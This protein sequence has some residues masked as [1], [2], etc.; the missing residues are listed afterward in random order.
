[1]SLGFCFETMKNFLGLNWQ[2]DFYLHKIT[3]P[4]KVADFKIILYIVILIYFGLSEFKKNASWYRYLT[5]QLHSCQHGQMLLL[6][7]LFTVHNTLNKRWSWL[8]TIIESMAKD[9]WKL[10]FRKEVSCCVYV[11]RMFCALWDEIKLRS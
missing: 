6:F 8:E 4:R 10:C 3:L 1:M 9:Q 2:T 5:C 7:A 11:Q